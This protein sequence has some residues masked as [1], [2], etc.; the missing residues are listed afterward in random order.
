MP[1]KPRLSSS[2][3]LIQPGVETRRSFVSCVVLFFLAC[4]FSPASSY[5]KDFIKG[6]FTDKLESVRRA[7]EAS[8][9]IFIAKAIDFAVSCHDEIGDD[10]ELESLLEYSIACVD[11][12]VLPQDRRNKLSA[13]LGRAF[14]SFSS[15]KVRLAVLDTFSSCM[16]DENLELVNAFVA[17]RAQEAADGGGDGS[18]GPVVEKS[19]LLLKKYGNRISFNILFIADLMDVWSGQ[20]ELLED[21]FAPLAASAENEIL[22]IADSAGVPQR[23]RILDIIGSGKGIPKKTKGKV[24][25]KLLLE[26]INNARDNGSVFSSEEDAL[27]Y[28][29]SVSL[30]AECRWTRVAQ[31]IADSFPIASKSYGWGLLDTDGF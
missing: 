11:I 22:K 17:S 23:M 29:Q 16:T 1:R 8:D 18:M 28:V 2:R 27:L 5:Q 26:Q 9:N 19:L 14:N 15:Q 21:S 24:A 25:E 3:I 13:D 31:D 7:Y 30:A 20:R 6:N 10:E 4:G 12:K